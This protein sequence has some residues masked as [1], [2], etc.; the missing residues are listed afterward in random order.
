MHRGDN[1]A[2]AGRTRPPWPKGPE[3]GPIAAFEPCRRNEPA[4]ADATNQEK[5]ATGLAQGRVMF[6]V[7][8]SR[9][10]CCSPPRQS[11]AA[12]PRCPAPANTVSAS[13]PNSGKA[14][15]LDIRAIGPKCS[16]QAWPYY[17]A[18]C[19]KGSPPSADAS[20]DRPHRHVGQISGTTVSR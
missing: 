16:E 15:R 18:D 7:L 4:G 12:P 6:K 17:E 1:P 3:I 20:Q 19:V 2:N 5:A 13:A 10:P 11:S 14:D 8:E 9:F